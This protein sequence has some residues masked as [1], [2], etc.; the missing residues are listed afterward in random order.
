MELK[1]DKTNLT[2]EQRFELNQ[3]IDLQRLTPSFI[4]IIAV[5]EHGQTQ[6]ELRKI[7]KLRNLNLFLTRQDLN[8]LDCIFGN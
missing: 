6:I 8:T 7:R 4:E 5:L 1:F 2:I 3:M